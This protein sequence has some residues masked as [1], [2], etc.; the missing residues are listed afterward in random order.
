MIICMGEVV[1]DMF[2]NLNNNII[3]K[4][5]L[6]EKIAQNSISEDIFA[7]TVSYSGIQNNFHIDIPEILIYEKELQERKN[8]IQ[9]FTN[10][11]MSDMD[12]LSHNDLVMELFKNGLINSEYEQIALA[13]LSTNESLI[14]DLQLNI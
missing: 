13:E 5:Q 10:L 11:V 8:D 3:S 9:K 14:K 12:N 4:S 1:E 2:N 6:H 7:K